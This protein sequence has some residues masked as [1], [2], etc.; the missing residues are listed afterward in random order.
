MLKIFKIKLQFPSVGKK[1]KKKKGIYKQEQHTWERNP[2]TRIRCER[3]S[4]KLKYS[5]ISNSIS[6]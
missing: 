4:K 3:N 1:K 6:N 5:A 2:H